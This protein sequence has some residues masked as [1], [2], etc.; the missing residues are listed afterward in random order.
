MKFC[1]HVFIQGRCPLNTTFHAF[2]F[3]T[4]LA[5]V[6]MLDLQIEPQCCCKIHK[7]Q[8]LNATLKRSLSQHARSHTH[9][10]IFISPLY[11]PIHPPLCFLLPSSL[12]LSG[13]LTHQLKRRRPMEMLS[14]LALACGWWWWWWGGGGLIALMNYICIIDKLYFCPASINIYLYNVSLC[15][16]V[17]GWP[18]VLKLLAG[19]PAQEWCQLCLYA[20]LQL[21]LLGG[22]RVCMQTKSLLNA[23]ID[24]Y[25]KWMFFWGNKYPTGTKPKWLLVIAK[26]YKLHRYINDWLM[27]W[28]ILPAQNNLHLLLAVVK[29]LHC[30]ANVI[31]N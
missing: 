28:L 22:D 29:Q 7:L 8:S 1:L 26:Q 9:P 11:P 27:G 3:F 5:P 14:G 25:S 12:D 6:V 18:S 15:L 23:P 30:S 17:T 19:R 31:H 4:A 24:S 2:F 16:I 13:H 20:G 21:G 10:L